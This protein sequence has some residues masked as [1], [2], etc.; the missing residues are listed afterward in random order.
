L[1]KAEAIEKAVKEAL[2]KYDD[3]KSQ[4]KNSKTLFIEDIVKVVP[5]SYPLKFKKIIKEM[6][7]AYDLKSISDEKILDALTKTNG[8]ADEALISL[9]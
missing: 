5:I 9:F 3:N 1:L 8:N 6:R 4:L 2:K 7:D